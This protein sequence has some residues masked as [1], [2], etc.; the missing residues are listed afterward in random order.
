MVSIRNALISDIDA[1]ER[2][3]SAADLPT[4]GIEDHLTTFFVADDGGG[5]SGAGGL[6]NCGE[7]VGL[8]RSFVVAPSFRNQ[9]IAVQM[10]ERV[11]AEADALGISTLYLLTTTAQ[12]YFAKRGFTSMA[13]DA[14]PPPIRQ[15]SQYASEPRCSA[16]T[17]M[18]R[19][20]PPLDSSVHELIQAF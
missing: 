5:L 3:L 19:K 20:A 1:I 12:D 2:L 6:E 18:C 14:A 8:L 13:R 10:L 11:C 7:G 15:T 17:L 9:G 4:E 16:A